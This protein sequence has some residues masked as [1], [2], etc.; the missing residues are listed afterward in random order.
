MG[1]LSARGE[2]ARSRREPTLISQERYTRTWRSPY[3][4]IHDLAIWVETWL[5]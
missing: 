1:G 5:S 3:R 2:F 4:P